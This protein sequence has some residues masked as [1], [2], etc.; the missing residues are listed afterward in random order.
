M[1]TVDLFVRTFDGQIFPVDVPQEY[2]KEDMHF[3]L[4]SLLEGVT[5]MHLSFD[6]MDRT[7]MI[8]GEEIQTDMEHAFIEA[9]LWLAENGIA[10]TED[11]FKTDD[12][13]T[14]KMLLRVDI[15][16]VDP[17][18]FC[19]HCV[20]YN[21]EIISLIYRYFTNVREIMSAYGIELEQIESSEDEW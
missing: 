6:R 8:S 12:V 21:Y 1:T 20:K 10:E 11:S 2:L 13:E 15:E 4:K 3:Y 16:P 19:H 18:I 5:G 14:V 7:D 9:K 17:D